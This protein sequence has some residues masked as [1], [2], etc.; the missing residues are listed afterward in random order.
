[1]KISILPGLFFLVFTS[2]T[3]AFDRTMIAEQPE[4]VTPLLNGQN[5]PAIE[6]KT[7]DGETVGLTQLVAQKPTILVF[8]RG[9]WC[10]YCSRQLAGLKDIESKL[11]D[12]GYQIIAISPDSPARLQAQKVKSEFNVML[13]SDD[14]L[15]A[16]RAFGLAFF[17]PEKTAE[18]YRNKLGVEFVD[19]YDTERVALP[20]PAVYIADQS[21]LIQFNYVNPNFKVRVSE[22]LLYDA[23]KTSLVK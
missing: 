17:L 3:L 4:Q 1:M 5:I 21:G 22:Q 19:V 16:T 23:A 13:L 2:V 15:A 7:V 11:T 10:P 8:Y 12:L 6:L 18:L 14:Q 20:V 9:G